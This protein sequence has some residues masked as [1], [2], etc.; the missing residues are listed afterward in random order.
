MT[1]H[2]PPRLRR[3][4]RTARR[5]VPRISRSRSTR[6]SIR[7]SR[8]DTHPE[9]AVDTGVYSRVTTPHPPPRG[10]GR[11][12][13]LFEG[14]RLHIHP[15][16]RIHHVQ[17]RPSLLARRTRRFTVL[18]YGG[19]GPPRRLPSSRGRVRRA[20]PY[21]RRSIVDE[22]HTHRRPRVGPRR[23]RRPARADR[24]ARR[25]EFATIGRAR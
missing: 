19:D 23:R 7:G 4:R 3:L 22:T 13:C 6:V 9:G 16:A 20:F 5:V 8:L 11:H 24:D 21:N 14:S 17:R 10:C 15:P 1:L 2:D 18:Q 25:R 12:G